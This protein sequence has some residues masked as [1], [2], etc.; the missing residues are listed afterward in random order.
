MV[1][2]LFLPCEIK[3]KTKEQNW[4]KKDPDCTFD[5]VGY[6]DGPASVLPDMSGRLTLFGKTGCGT[7]LFGQ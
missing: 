6:F 3:K 7:I 5:V 4:Q 2:G 1:S